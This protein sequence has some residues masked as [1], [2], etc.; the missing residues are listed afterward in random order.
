MGVN[1]VV[2]GGVLK[3]VNYYDM[4]NAVVGGGS[5]RVDMGV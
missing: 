1:R 2:N 3:G 4:L 5:G